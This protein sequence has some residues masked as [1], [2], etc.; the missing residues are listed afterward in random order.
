MH[1]STRERLEAAAMYLAVDQDRDRVRDMLT[2]AER[3]LKRTRPTD[4]DAYLTAAQAV[5][6]L[7]AA[8]DLLER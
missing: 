5:A 1:P 2:N 6:G 3:T 7:R 4:A 8:L